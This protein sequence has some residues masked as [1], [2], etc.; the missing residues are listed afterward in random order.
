M[1][2]EKTDWLKNTGISYIGSVFDYFLLSVKC[3][4]VS[5]DFID[6]SKLITLISQKKF[7]WAIGMLFLTTKQTVGT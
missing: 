2:K 5:V 4:L 1:K 7:G 3:T 6:R